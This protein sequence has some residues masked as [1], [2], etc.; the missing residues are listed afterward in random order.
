[1]EGLAT[2]GS[3]EDWLAHPGT[4]GRAATA[5]GID[6]VILD[7][8]GNEA[9]AGVAGLVYM[10][11]P[12]GQRFEYEGAP[13]STASAWRDDLFTVGDVGYLDEEGLAL[14]DRPPEGRRDHRRRERL[15]GRGRAC[16]RLA[17]E[18][19]RGRGD[20]RSRRRMGR[21]GVRRRRVRR[22]GVRRRADRVLPGAARSYKCPRGIEFVD[23]LEVDPLGKVLKRGLRER[24]WSESQRHI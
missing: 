17:P 24:Y 1:M 3:P 14:P 9:P 19:R 15:P 4:V 5:L 11:P 10:R 18:R 2:I 21:V 12:S 20:R 22:T 16:P 8:D 23:E 13:E 6:V 7:D